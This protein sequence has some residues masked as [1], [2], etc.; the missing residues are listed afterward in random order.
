MLPNEN[1]K[2]FEGNHHL[3]ASEIELKARFNEGR[4]K[5]IEYVLL[6]EF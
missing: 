3:L 2:R 5:L 4:E 6:S 1:K